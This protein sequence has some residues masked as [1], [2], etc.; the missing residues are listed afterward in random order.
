MYAVH[1]LAVHRKVVW[2]YVEWT[3]YRPPLTTF[4][5]PFFL[6][7][8]GQ[9]LGASPF[10]RFPR[11]HSLFCVRLNWTTFIGK[12]K[13]LLFQ[14]LSNAF[15]FIIVVFSY[16]LYDL[17][18]WV[19]LNHSPFQGSE[20]DQS[21][22]GPSLIISDTCSC[23]ILSVKWRDKFISEIVV[24]VIASCSLDAKLLCTAFKI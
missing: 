20:F 22:I 18:C 8:R 3:S 2:R 5:K 23:S 1:R 12:E 7:S 16:E 10:P 21:S 17:Y 6:R 4:V 15:V 14:A 13:I 11:C 9:D 24:I 19:K